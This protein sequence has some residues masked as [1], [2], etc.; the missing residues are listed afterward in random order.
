MNS[1]LP[2]TILLAPL[3]SAV[4]ITLFTLRWKAAEQFNLGCGRPGEFHVQLL[5]LSHN[6]VSPR[7][8]SP[9][10][11]LAARSKYRLALRSIN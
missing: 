7:L 4:V 6:P 5:D 11:I 8:S 1:I 3:A 2:W 9:G 10:S